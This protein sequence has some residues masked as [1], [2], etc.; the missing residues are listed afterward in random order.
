MTVD[1][2]C[3][4]AGISK[5]DR[6]T[7]FRDSAMV[8]LSLVTPHEAEAA[9][10]AKCYLERLR[11]VLPGLDVKVATLPQETPARPSCLKVGWD[12]PRRV[13][14]GEVPKPKQGDLL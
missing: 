13:F 11:R 6:G 4:I 8:G 3:A 12:K 5:W 10:I 2:L 9:T 1:R 7:W 14:T